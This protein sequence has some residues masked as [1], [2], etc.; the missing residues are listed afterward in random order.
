[1][2]AMPQAFEAFRTSTGRSLSL[3]IEPGNAI[4]SALWNLQHDTIRCCYKLKNTSNIN[5]RVFPFHTL[6]HTLRYAL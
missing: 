4:C 2:I 3:E 5:H 1:M 6:F